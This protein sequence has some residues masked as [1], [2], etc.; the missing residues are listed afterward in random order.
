MNC[1]LGKIRKPNV[2]TLKD[3]IMCICILHNILVDNNVPILAELDRERVPDFDT[4]A[5]GFDVQTQ[6]TKSREIRKGIAT[7]ISLL[8]SHSMN[9]YPTSI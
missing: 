9:E 8:P 2:R 1:F 3:Y 4:F 5:R 7:Y 6:F